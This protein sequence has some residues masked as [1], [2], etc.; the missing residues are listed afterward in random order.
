[1]NRNYTE[2]FEIGLPVG[3]K[4]NKPKLI[5]SH[6]E[7]RS[8]KIT[9]V[10]KKRDVFITIRLILSKFRLRLRVSPETFTHQWF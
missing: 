3:I 4:L 2:L 6:E 9:E 1:M 10:S 8:L 7:D 5:V